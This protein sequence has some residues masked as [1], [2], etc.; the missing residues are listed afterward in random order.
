MVTKKSPS[1][2][3]QERIDRDGSPF[4]RHSF[5]IILATTFEQVVPDSDLPASAK[6]KPL[7]FVEITNNSS[8][9]LEAE[10]NNEA[11]NRFPLPAGTIRTIDR[12]A[13]WNL[14]IVNTD[15][16]DTSN[17]EVIAVF[18]RLPIDADEAA[19]RAG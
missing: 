14:R 15:A 16:T 3:R 17:G 11:T 5:G 1:K 4:F 9:D 7:D 2:R 19:R 10:I 8:E 18:Q 6:Y 13:I 12:R